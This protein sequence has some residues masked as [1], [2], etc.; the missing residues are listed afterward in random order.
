MADELA[1]LGYY[2]PT[3]AHDVWSLGLLLLNVFG[4]C[5]PH[6]HSAA[7]ATEDN[8]VTLAY[9]RSLLAPGVGKVYRQQAGPPF[10]YASCMLSSHGMMSSG[11]QGLQN[12]S[13]L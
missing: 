8:A 10:Q 12:Y 13:S 11:H 4:G 1:R 9:A 6:Q 2:T 3:A 7:I 5:R